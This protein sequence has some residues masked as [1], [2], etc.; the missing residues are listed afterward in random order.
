MIV[1]IKLEGDQGLRRCLVPDL[2]GAWAWAEDAVHMPD[3]FR[4]E[5][6]TCWDATNENVSDSAETT[7]QHLELFWTP[8]VH[9]ARIRAKL[10]CYK[11]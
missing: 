10:S 3:C 5:A 6:E 4:G 1:I 11:L 8:A 2:N 9:G 7:Q